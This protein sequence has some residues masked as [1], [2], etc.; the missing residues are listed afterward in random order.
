M[1]HR[2]HRG[3]LASLIRR[4]GLGRNPL[5]RAVDRT[6][7]AALLAAIMVAVIVIPIASAFGTAVYHDNLAE[8]V[9][10]SSARHQV[11]GVLMDAAPLTV[12]EA[13][14]SALILV[15]ARWSGPNGVRHTGL[16]PASIG[17]KAGSPVRIWND[18][19]GNL[20]DAPITAAQAKTRG[21]VVTMLIMMLTLAV[22]ATLFGIVRM[23]LNRVRSATWDTEW[24]RF[25]PQWTT[26]AN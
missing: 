7:N 12:T 1:K 2:R 10:Q 14:G 15:N 25:G 13:G 5:R 24:R 4:F 26:R 3:R 18:R 22:L 23:R 19:Y 8:S 21:L 20:A 17:D 9:T 11:T 16:A 6:E